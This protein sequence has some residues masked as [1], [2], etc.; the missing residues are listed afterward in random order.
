MGI[1]QNKN[2][3][4]EAA[5]TTND[6]VVIEVKDVK[7][8]FR[9]YQDKAT[10]FKE[11]FV[12][13]SRGKHEDIM[14]L[15]GISF[16]VKRGEAIGIIGKNGCGK[17]TTLKLLT[18][19]LYPNE[20]QIRMK[21]RVSSLIE[22]GA[23]FH[24]DMTGRENIYTNASI[25]GITRKE[26]DLRLNDIIRFSELEDYIDS[27]VRTYSSGMYMR[28]AFA[29]AINVDADILLIDEILAVGDSAFQKKCFEKLKE[30]KANG[31]TIVIVS[32]SMDQ[33]YK[34]CDRLIWL[35][36]GLVREEGRPRIV[37]EE[38]LAAMEGRRLDRLEL[39]KQQEREELEE[40][41]AAER[42]KLLREE[43][44]K[45]GQ[46]DEAGNANKDKKAE[47]DDQ[48]A[49]ALRELE[50]KQRELERNASLKSVCKNCH[51]SAHRGGNGNIVYTNAT[52]LNEKGEETSSIKT[53]EKCK[54][55][56]KYKVVKESG[57][58]V[59]VMGITHEDGTYCY[60]TA[61]DTSSCKQSAQ[62]DTGT[63]IFSFQNELL[64]GKY[65]LDLWIQSADETQFDAVYSLMLFEVVTKASQECG[66]FTMP[67]TWTVE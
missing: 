45:A 14:V 29:V 8:K 3:K 52:L 61:I 66:F 4:E 40:K 56:L 33:M 25:F 30:I 63:V 15:K 43:E 59:F 7:K 47:E 57:K 36:N 65:Y 51:P 19:I 39:E 21:G 64:A 60:G 11:R 37:G 53:G 38:Y 50:R 54:L 27:P 41:V 55:V 49:E 24:P 22:L 1:L 2:A 34:I 35:E 6:E 28:L 23:G 26:V 10:S 13:P 16:Q 42:E 67:H 17:S 9:S 58:P 62:K 5:E 44:H 31:T 32:H 12:N 48:R 20:G 46:A 18:R